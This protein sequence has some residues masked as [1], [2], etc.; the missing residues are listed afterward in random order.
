MTLA[1][2]LTLA[3]V[4]VC[5]QSGAD[6]A[7]PPRNACQGYDRPAKACKTCEHCYYCGKK[8]KWGKR[9]ENSATCTACAPDAPRER[10]QP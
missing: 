8:G 2:A 6:A 1:A 5:T 7:D 10:K 4:A 9:P 3:I